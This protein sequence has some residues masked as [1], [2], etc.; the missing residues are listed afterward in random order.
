MHART[1]LSCFGSL[2]LAAAATANDGAAGAPQVDARSAFERFKSLSGTWQ[3]ATTTGTHTITYRVASAGSVVMETLFPH[4]PH[5]MVT[6]YHLDGDQLVATHYCAAGNQPRFRF[7]PATSA[8]DR[9]HLAFA[10][11]SN[12]KPEDGH[13]HEGTFQFLDSDH[14]NVEWVHWRGGSRESAIEFTMV[15]QPAGEAPPQP[16]SPGATGG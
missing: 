2:L 7:D 13:I 3:A 9:Y 10:G 12:M 11:S 16:A 14:V 5:E 6:M 1:V 15:R 8:P 4:T